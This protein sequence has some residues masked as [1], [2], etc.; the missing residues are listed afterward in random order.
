[1]NLQLKKYTEQLQEWPQSGH[2]I[3]AQY[4]EEKIIVYQSYRPEIGNFAVKNQF[5]GGA[6]SLDRMTWIKPN[7]LWMMYRNGWGT[8]E[9][10][11]VV[12][13]IHLKLEA[14]EKYLENAVY[15]SFNQ[16][17]GM[18]MEQWQE[19]VKT[20]NVRLQW[21]PDHDP[22]GNKLERRAIQIGLRNEFS[23]SF[24][25]TDILQ[26]EN[27]SPFVAEQYEFVK[28]NELEQLIIPEEKPLRFKNEELNKKLKLQ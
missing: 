19:A 22:Y 11:E 15:S 1:M 18:S 5:F 17:E 20:S 26:I 24:A 25:K 27:I 14:F 12:L 8:K 16:V 28:K 2:H 23:R 9:G 4:D 21:D 7:F 13:A 6:F 10:Q 3:M